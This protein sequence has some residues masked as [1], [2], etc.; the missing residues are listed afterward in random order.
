MAVHELAVNSE[1]QGKLYEEVKEY[2]EKHGKMTYEGV[3]KMTYLDCV[4]NGK[5]CVFEHCGVTTYHYL[6]ISNATLGCQI[7][8]RYLYESDRC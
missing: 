6:N 1:A 5:T 4:A 8:N 7:G 3:Q 2:H